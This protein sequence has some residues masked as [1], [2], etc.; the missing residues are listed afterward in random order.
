MPKSWSS[1]TPG[2]AGSRELKETAAP[3]TIGKA[4]A[5]GIIVGNRGYPSRGPVVADSRHPLRI[6]M[7]SPILPSC[8]IWHFADDQITIYQATLDRQ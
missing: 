1:P 8:P 4:R 6:D 7:L 5:V 3:P 2:K